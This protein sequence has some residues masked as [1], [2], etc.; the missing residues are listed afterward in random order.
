MLVRDCLQKVLFSALR[1]LT[2]PKGEI[3]RRSDD[4]I[5]WCV[6]LNPSNEVF[7]QQKDLKIMSRKISSFLVAISDPNVR[8][9]LFV[10]KRNILNKALELTVGDQATVLVD[11]DTNTSITAIIK[12][13]IRYIGPLPG[14]TGSY[15]GI[16][17]LVSVTLNFEYSV[18]LSASTVYI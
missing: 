6:V 8:L 18:F 2:V 7:C 5:S 11:D 15:F 14:M 16:E 1:D 10:N 12:A 9:D 17:L 13:V 4:N 3:V